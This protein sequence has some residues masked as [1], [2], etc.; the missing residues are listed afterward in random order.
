[1]PVSMKEVQ[2]TL[3]G[4]L[5]QHPD[6]LQDLDIAV[7]AM[8]DE[9]DITTRDNLD[10]HVTCSVAAINPRGEMLE[11]Q[12]RFLNLW[13][14]PGGHLDT[15][16]DTLV[17]SALRELT[18][19]TGLI[20]TSEEPVGGAPVDVVFGNIP[21]RPARGEPAHWHLD[22]CFAFLIEQKNEP[23]DPAGGREAGLG[24]RLDASEVTGARWTPLQ[25]TAFERIRSRLAVLLDPDD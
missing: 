22:F 6:E 15:C 16:D 20:P 2:A 23:S 7:R 19:E 9:S 18:E 17:G 10:G 14:P 8:L 21:D 25:A 3:L 13:L 11:I 4:Y 1:M 12:H 5:A 24:L